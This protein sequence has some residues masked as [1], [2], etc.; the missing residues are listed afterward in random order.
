MP[1]PVKS[2]LFDDVEKEEKKNSTGVFDSLLQPDFTTPPQTTPPQAEPT[3]QDVLRT[4]LGRGANALNTGLLGAQVGGLFGPAGAAVGGVG[5]ALAGA[6]LLDPSSQPFTDVGATLGELAMNR[7]LPGAGRLTRM[8]GMAAGV[9]GGAGIGQLADKTADFITETSYGPVAIYSGLTGVSELTRIAR[10]PNHNLADLVNN[11]KQK[12]GVSI[13]LS[14]SETTGGK[15]FTPERFFAHGHPLFA[16]LGAEQSRAGLEILDKILGKPQDNLVTVVRKA[17]ESAQEKLAHAR[18]SFSRPDF[19]VLGPKGIKRLEVG[20]SD[21]L[22]YYGITADEWEKV[23]GFI[24]SHPEE[25]IEKL[26]PR[27]GAGNLKGWYGLSG[28]IKI[29][30][31][32]GDAETAGK[33]ATAVIQR[34]LQKA[35]K[36]HPELGYVIT[37]KRFAEEVIKNIGPERLQLA[38]GKERAEALKELAL[39]MELTNPIGK[40]GD[41]SRSQAERSLSYL[42]NKA[43]FALAFGG[44]AGG[45]TGNIL[46]GLAGGMAI[47]PLSSAIAALMT[48]PKASK[49]F[50]K[51]AQGD[52]TAVAR[53]G[54]LFMSPSESPEPV[55]EQKLPGL[56]STTYHGR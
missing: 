7:L 43:A 29:L 36:P 17:T 28:I 53:L 38:L 16:R 45:A 55:E 54:R 52:R 3:P 11:L 14:M 30:D 41:R 4:F 8:L 32:E 23:T 10:I 12:T 40:I 20:E 56:F 21:I 47:I 18:E 39:V 15:F 34:T 31:K 35:I 9:A 48:N 26:I 33:L 19:F 44:V 50:L 2:G 22:K 13:P 6:T 25:A 5:G 46:Q 27:G 1:E 24:K 37:G 42:G 51:A 49:V